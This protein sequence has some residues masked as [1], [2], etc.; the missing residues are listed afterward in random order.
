MLQQKLPLSNRFL[1]AVSALDPTARGHSVTFSH[2]QKL[3]S[4][5]VNV[6][7]E[8]EEGLYELEIRKY[9]TDTLPYFDVDSSRIDKWWC[10]EEVTCKYPALSKM[11]KAL[12]SCFHG[13]QVESSFSVMNDI[14]DSKSGKLKIET[15]SAIQNVK[16]S[17]K[18]S[19]KSSLEYFCKKDYLHDKIDRRLLMNM[20]SARSHYKVQL[21]SNQAALAEKKQELEI[22]ATKVLSKRKANELC[23]KAAKKARL[24]HHKT[25]DL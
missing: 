22:K 5:V 19:N 11:A 7:T 13:P 25:V 3:P 21:A 24:S 16:Y 20:Q 8:E 14:I 10:S 23:S 2:M 18:A 15:Y 9:Q 12:L 1:K 4:I 17:I 6:L